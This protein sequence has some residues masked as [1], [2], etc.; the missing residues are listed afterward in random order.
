MANIGIPPQPPGDAAISMT[1]W[2]WLKFVWSWIR[3]E[4]NVIQSQTASI[5][6]SDSFLYPFD[7]T[8][9]SLIATLPLAKSYLGKKYVIKK[10]DNTTHTVTITAS[11]TDTIDGLATQ[12]LTSQY[13]ELEIVFGL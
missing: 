10:T 5:T 6:L 8:V 1:T 2:G 7:T 3:G 4:A 13:A 12:I 11:G 9:A